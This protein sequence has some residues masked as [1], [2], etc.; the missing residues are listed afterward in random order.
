MKLAL[1]ISSLGSGG[2]ERVLS[3][4]ANHWAK[5]GHD[6]HLVT[7]AP[8]SEIPFYPLHK[9]VKPH[10]LDL[11]EGQVSGI[12]R[13]FGIVG[14]LY[15]LRQKIKQISPD[16]ILSFIDV[17][18]VTVLLA[19][20]GLRIPV[21]VSE[22]T[23]PH[24]HRIP[25]IY[26][27]IRQYIYTYS[28]Q[29]IV[30]TKS[31]SGY[32]N[33]IKNVSVI[34]NIIHSFQNRIRGSIKNTSLISVGRL[35]L[36]KNFN[37]LIQAF[38]KIHPDFPNLTL[39]I[40]GEGSERANLEN[41]I[42]DLKLENHVFLPGVVSDIQLKLLEADL[43]VFPSQYEGFPNALCE[44]M[45]V[46]LPVIAS[47]CSGNIDVVQDG[48]NGVLVDVGDLD[49]LVQALTDLL[50]DPEKRCQIGEK[51]KEITQTYSAKK[52]YTLWDE[53]VIK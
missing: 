46:G 6:V 49:G 27:I 39:T 51:A 43:F 12:K 24:F 33:N 3:D 21:I 53:I 13:L 10:S 19:T 9:N 28:K 20:L 48:V 25:R 8:K 26:K 2:A 38:S 16:R 30:Q 15:H 34:P 47:N 22:R 18:N 32:F 41:L 11:L 40:Y 36:S 1:V 52:I 4:L 37:V 31:A 35:I 42:N 29:V 45:A 44:A 14:R 17:M 7:F 50:V 23:D 5:G